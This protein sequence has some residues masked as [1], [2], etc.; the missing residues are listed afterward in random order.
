LLIERAVEI[1][2]IFQLGR[3]FADALDLRVPGP[4]GELVTPT[5]GTYG[6]G[7]SRAVRALAE[8]TSGALGL[9]WPPAVAPADVHLVVAGRDEDVV[10]AADEIATGLAEAGATVLYDDRTEASAGVKF[11]DAE[12]IG[13]PLIV[14]VGRGL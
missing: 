12:L 5:M 13:V 9:C 1:G 4:D 11:A 2:H 6:I 10:D 7:I 8:P 3:K 14:V